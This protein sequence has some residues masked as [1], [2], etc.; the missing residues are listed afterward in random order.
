MCVRH[1]L[2]LMEHCARIS[3]TKKEVDVFFLI[4]AVV[5][6]LLLLFRVQDRPDLFFILKF[7]VFSS[8][9]IVKYYTCSF[10]P[11]RSPVTIVLLFLN[12]NYN[13]HL[14]SSYIIN[15]IT[16]FVDGEYK[17]RVQLDSWL[18]VR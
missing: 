18:S 2:K 7:V 1:L 13:T 11:L 10:F 3:D 12:V 17:P 8:V 6:V 16:K 9:L 5:L 4:S 14:C 15:Y